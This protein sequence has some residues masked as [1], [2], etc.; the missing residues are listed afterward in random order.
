MNR[1][2]G[3]AAPERERYGALDGL[4][5][6][7]CVGIVLMHVLENCTVK[8][9][10]NWLVRVIA[11]SGN[12]VLLF[13]MVS[14]FSVSCGYFKG[15]REG[16]VLPRDFYGKRYSRVLPFFALLVFIDVLRTFVSEGFSLT[17]VMRAELYEAYADVTLLFGL[18]PDADISV[19]GVG[20][21]LGVIFLFYLMFP[22]FTFLLES[23]RRGWWVLLLSVGLYFST[24]WYFIPVKHVMNTPCNLLLCGPYFMAGGLIFLYRR[25]I[26]AGAA[27]RFGG[28]PVRYLLLAVTLLYTVFFFGFPAGRIPLFS[29]LLLFVLWMVYAVSENAAPER[30]TFLRNGV[31]RFFS[32]ISMEVYLCHMMFFR[33]AEKLYFNK[34]ISDNDVYYVC[35]CVFVLTGSVLFALGWKRVLKRMRSVG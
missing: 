3:A 23:R 6:L 35:M 31:M 18:M 17:E 11:Y 34:Y 7:A 28:V 25:D 14:A 2:R 16:S 15:I 26:A 29:L 5:T 24:A 19:V 33:I 22:F 8:P 12:F 1:E 4:R 32:G 10:E 9:T 13:M 27:V 20:W 21:F 30:C